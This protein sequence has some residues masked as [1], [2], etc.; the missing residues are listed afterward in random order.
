MMSVD[1]KAKAELR[2][3]LE[4]MPAAAREALAPEINAQGVKFYLTEILLVAQRG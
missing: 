1:E 3:M 4:T 2:Q